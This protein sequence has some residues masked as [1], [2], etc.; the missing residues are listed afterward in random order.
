MKTKEEVLSILKTHPNENTKESQFKKKFPEHYQILSTWIFP[1][2]FKFTQKLFHY[3]NDDPELKLGLCPVCGKRCRFLSIT[4]EY[5]KYCS[6]ECYGKDCDNW[7]IIEPINISK[8][9]ILNLLKEH[10]NGYI[11]EYKFRKIFPQYYIEIINWIFPKDFKW[12]Q[13]LYHYLHNDRELKLGICPVCGKRCNFYRFG[14]G[15]KKHCSMKCKSLDPNIQNKTKRTC[16]KL[17]GKES[18]SQTEESKERI[19]KTTFQR[20]GVDCYAKTEES[21]EKA[22]KTCLERYGEICFSKTNEWSSKRR[23]KI[24]YDNLSF[25]SSWEVIIY[26]Y[27]KENNILCEYQPNILFNYEYNGKKHKYQPDFLIND[28]IYEVKGNHFFEGDKMICPFDR[29]KDDLFEAK[30]QC[31]LSNNVII[32][33]EYEINHINEFIKKEK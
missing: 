17:Y 32:L 22:K 7:K 15:Y 26:Q 10:P 19:K 12:T 16:L 18:Y 6:S 14:K 11:E 33:T 2:D 21:K 13:K 23:K 24:K 8:E 29:N 20:Y 28:K 1:S 9:E 27:C 25:D 31:M 3:F 5:S 4:R 30:H